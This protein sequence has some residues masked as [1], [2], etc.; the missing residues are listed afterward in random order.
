MSIK[1]MAATVGFS[2]LLSAPVFAKKSDSDEHKEHHNAASYKQK[3]DD[4]HGHQSENKYQRS[5]KT[6]TLTWIEKRKYILIMGR[7]NLGIALPA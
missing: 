6:A 4:D 5:K 3:H 1:L 7:K 2:M